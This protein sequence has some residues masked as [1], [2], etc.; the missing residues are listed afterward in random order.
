MF[1]KSIVDKYMN[2]LDSS[3]IENKFN[4]FQE[5]YGNS[6][7]QKNI[8][9]LKEEQYQEGFIRDFF[10]TVLGYT[11]KP[12]ANYNIL[13]ELKNETKN[14]NNSRKADGAIIIN[15]LTKAVI[16][17]KG[18]NIQDLDS[19]ARQAFDYKSH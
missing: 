7:K 16:E 9:S 8:C 10:C 13:T 18:T 15:G 6:E 2:Y 19:V 3:V 17:L 5:V 1:Q 12:E 14:K 4:T 11:I